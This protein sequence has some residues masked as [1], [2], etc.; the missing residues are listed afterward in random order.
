MRAAALVVLAACVPKGRYELAT[1]QLEAT[2]T[3]LS[4]R[5]GECARD[6][7]EG[8]AQRQELIGEIARR[9]LQLDELQARASIRDVTLDVLQSRELTLRAEVDALAAE[10]DALRAAWPRR[11]PAPPVP[12]AATPGA[13]EGRVEAAAALQAH[14]H[15]DLERRRVEE[16]RAEDAAAFA[17]LVESGRAT[18]TG[19]GTATVVSLPTELLFQEGF[20]TLSARG[21]Q[22][23][24]EVAEALRRVPGRRLTIEGHTDARPVHTAEFPSNW[25]R[26]FGQAVALLHALEA[27]E[28]PVGLS[29]ASFGGTRPLG[30]DEGASRRLEL[31]LSLDPDLATAFAPTAP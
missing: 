29:A 4:A 28:V 2:R 15:E 23:A 20:S 19:R 1:V 25:E 12:P 21:R 3:A 26:G 6:A 22:I 14:F 9:Q 16:A 30:A 18:L 11:G 24:L 31:V 17:G 8:R 10:R 7:N 5:T 13:D 27:E